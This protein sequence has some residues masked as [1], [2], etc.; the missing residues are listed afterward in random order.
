MVLEVYELLRM[1]GERECGI[2]SLKSYIESDEKWMISSRSLPRFR[3]LSLLSGSN[4]V[5]KPA[6]V[7]VDV[8]EWIATNHAATKLTR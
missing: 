4:I 2:E 1:G 8:D 7:Q 5:L 6:R 3:K